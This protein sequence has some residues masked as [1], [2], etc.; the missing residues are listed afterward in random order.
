[1]LK[2]LDAIFDVYFLPSHSAPLGLRY[3]VNPSGFLVG[4]P[5]TCSATHG[6][7]L[8]GLLCDTLPTPLGYGVSRSRSQA[9]LVTSLKHCF[10]AFREPRHFDPVSFPLGRSLHFARRVAVASF[11]SPGARAPPPLAPTDARASS[12]FGAFHFDKLP[13]AVLV[14]CHLLTV[15][16][17]RLP[18]APSQNR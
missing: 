14:L 6:Y 17:R 13:S 1:M 7:P 5:A 18:L 8:R 16:V 2:G 12:R 4:A 11:Q 9:T 15:G 10:A 3:S